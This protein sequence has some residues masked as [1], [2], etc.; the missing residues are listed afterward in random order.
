MKHMNKIFALVLALVMILG[1]ASFASADEVETYEVT[2]K[3]ATGHEYVIYQIFT[4]DLATKDGKEVLS[5]VKYGADYAP[6]GK[7]VGDPFWKTSM[8]KTS[9]PPA[10][11]L[12]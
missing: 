1:L 11:V 10:R 8:L 6:T 3:N 5:N 2:I 12:Q 7:N 4:G 9:L